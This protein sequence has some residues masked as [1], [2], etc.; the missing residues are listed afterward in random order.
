[1]SKCISTAISLTWTEEQVHQKGA[2]FLA[3]LK[4]IVA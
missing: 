2:A 1:M 3:V 4:Q